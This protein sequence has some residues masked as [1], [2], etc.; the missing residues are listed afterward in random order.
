VHF[1]V[2]DRR[3]ELVVV[4]FQNSHHAEFKAIH[5]KTREDCDRLVI[6]RMNGLCK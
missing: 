1:V 2:C 5:P 4:D 3:G 6:R